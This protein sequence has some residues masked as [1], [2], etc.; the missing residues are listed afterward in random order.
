MKK[1]T[2]LF[3]CTGNSAR[4]QMAEGLLREFAGD[5]FDVQRQDS[6]RKTSTRWPS[7]PWRKSALISAAIDPRAPKNF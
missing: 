4:S 2:V 7:K 1:P 3:V 6:T 5:E